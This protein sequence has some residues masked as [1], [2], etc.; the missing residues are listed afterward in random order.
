MKSDLIHDVTV[1]ILK[2]I[3]TGNIDIADIY[4]DFVVKM[5]LF[6]EELVVF[7]NKISKLIIDHNLIFWIKRID[8]LQ[9]PIDFLYLFI[10]DF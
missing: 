7:S 1:D 5:H 10:D 3:D 6:F 9:T 8:S 2:N 4:I